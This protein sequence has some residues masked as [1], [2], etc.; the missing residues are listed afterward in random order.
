MTDFH[1][2]LAGSGRVWPCDSSQRPRTSSLYTVQTRTTVRSH[3]AIPKTNI[4]CIIWKW[5]TSQKLIVISFLNWRQAKPRKLTCTILSHINSQVVDYG[6]SRHRFP[7]RQDTIHFEKVI[8]TLFK[9]LFHQVWSLSYFIPWQSI[10]S[11]SEHQHL[12]AL[13][14]S[15][16]NLGQ[17]RS[18]E[19]KPMRWPCENLVH[20]SYCVRTLKDIWDHGPHQCFVRKVRM[21]F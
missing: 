19:I 12:M 1:P 20:A 2:W 9:T 14:S 7:A 15:L 21:W 11:V 13:A 10:T 4:V 6:S 16:L 5:G 8:R 3:T 18:N 17:A